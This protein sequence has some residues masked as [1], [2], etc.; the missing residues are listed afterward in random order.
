MFMLKW[1]L[2]FSTLIN[3]ASQKYLFHFCKKLPDTATNEPSDPIFN[4]AE[5][6]YKN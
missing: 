6:Y 3:Q 5:G 1:F 4:V 2:L